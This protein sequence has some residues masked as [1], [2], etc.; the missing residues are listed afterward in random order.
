MAHKI[1]VK[2]ILDACTEPFVIV[3]K[4][5]DLYEYE[6]GNDIDILARE[7]AQLVK[8][9]LHV[10]TSLVS[11]EISIKVTIYDTY[12]QSIFVHGHSHI[13]FMEGDVLIIRLDIIDTLDIFKDTLLINNDYA[14]LAFRLLEYSISPHKQ[15]HLDFVRDKLNSI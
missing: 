4:D 14:Q 7:A 5:K 10:S 3:K 15:K 1:D 8:E 6:I 11:E 13:D 12:N 9:I 2:T